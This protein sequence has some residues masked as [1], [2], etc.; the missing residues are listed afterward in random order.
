MNSLSNNWFSEGNIDFELKKYTLLAYLVNINS[1]LH[2]NQLYPALSDLIFHYNNLVSFKKNKESLQNNFPQRL[3][4]ASFEELKLTYERMILD[5][6]IIREIEEIIYFSL[7]KMEPSIKEGQEIYDFVDGNFVISPVGLLPIQKDRGYLFLCDGNE[8]EIGVYSYH[9][10]FFEDHLDKYRGIHTEYVSSYPRNF[11]NTYPQIKV[12]LLKR[13]EGT[14][15]PA[16]YCI[17]TPLTFPIQETLLPIARQTL[18]RY[19]STT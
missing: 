14:P 1:L 9:I 5:D 8:R 3:S 15:N 7:Q 16:V 10:T 4:Q 2:K 12:D 19:I 18:V 13:K 17:E 6:K 11:I